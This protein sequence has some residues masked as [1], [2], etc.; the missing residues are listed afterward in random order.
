MTTETRENSTG[1]Q[2]GKMYTLITNDENTHHIPENIASMIGIVRNVMDMDE[3]DD[4]DEDI[5]EDRTIPLP[6]I[7]TAVLN[8]IIIY[9]EYYITHTMPEPPK[10]LN[11]K[12]KTF[13][14]EQN[15]MWYYDYADNMSEEHLFH[16]MLGA[17]YM[18]IQ[19]LLNLLCAYVGDVVKTKSPEEIRTL[20][21]IENDFSPEEE[22]AIRE[23]NKWCEEL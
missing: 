15:V 11:K 8:D 2:Q 9:C 17:N 22:A 5:D 23:E 7:N 10:P 18:D 19:P 20:F 21:N 13:F 14:E 6:N 12:L 16:V 4:D 3:E 1:I